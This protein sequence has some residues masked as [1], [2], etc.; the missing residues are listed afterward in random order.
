P[1]QV[2]ASKVVGGK[3]MR[4]RPLCAYPQTAR[5]TGRGSIDDASNYVC[6]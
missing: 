4:T 6:R 2:T 3:V 5:Y 1:S